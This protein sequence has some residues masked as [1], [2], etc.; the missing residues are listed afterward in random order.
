MI[1]NEIQFHAPRSLA[2]AL[3]LLAADG[4][5]LT[6]LSGGMSLLPMMNLG[7]IRPTKVLSLNRVPELT[8]VSERDGQLVI[9]AMVRHHRIASDPLIQRHAPLLAAA[10]RV[11]G[12]V[13]VRNRGTIG[14]SVAHADPSAD[15]L[16]ALAA[17][18][19]TITLAS[20]RGERTL[21]PDEFFIDLML[22]SREPEEVVTAVTV[23]KLPDGWRS[24]FQRLARVEG[25]FA[26]VNAAAVLAGDR[27]VATVA[28][29]GVGP[30]PMVVDASEQLRDGV[31]EQALG[32]VGE[33]VHEAARDATGDLMSD[34]TYRRE[35]ASVFAKRALR[36]AAGLAGGTRGSGPAGGGSGP[37]GGG[38]GTA[39]P[40]SPSAEVR[41]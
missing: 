38:P 24:A 7:I 19:G 14:G 16:P 18:A 41:S 28:L 9:G 13:Q 29:G 3:D 15:Y 33:A 5:D 40:Q 4:D 25:S 34:A 36:E 2:E 1:S 6:V 31:D 21:T 26:I 32:R 12:D 27:S 30:R 8:H 17:A 20:A 23:P 22:T 39:A 37:S 35:M 10:A 11:V